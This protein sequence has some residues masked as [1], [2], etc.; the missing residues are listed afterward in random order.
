MPPPAPSTPQ[1]P[2]SLLAHDRRDNVAVVVVEN[3][4]AG[5]SLRGV[6][7]DDDSEFT[8]PAQD[9]APLGHKLA[10]SDLKQGDAAVKYGQDIGAMTRDAKRGEHVHTHNLKTSRW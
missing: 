7:L 4:S 3:V 9:A 8:L 2:V 10:L 6:F 1:T 5:D